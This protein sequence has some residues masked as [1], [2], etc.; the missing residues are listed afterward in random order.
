M[1][2][3]FLLVLILFLFILTG[4][5]SSSEVTY[6]DLNKI[7]LKYENKYAD[8][9]ENKQ[10]YFSAH[11]QLPIKSETID[12]NGIKVIVSGG[13]V[14]LPDEALLIMQIES[15]R[16]ELEST[17]TDK[18]EKNMLDKYIEQIEIYENKHK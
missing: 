3:R 17:S 15:M 10:Y 4:C 18:I 9:I 13:Q 12:S 16:H 6:E 2:T 8:I 7:I 5:N 14:E 11:E 1:N